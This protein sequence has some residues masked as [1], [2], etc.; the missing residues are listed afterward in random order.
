VQMPPKLYVTFPS[1]DFR[2]MPC[3][4]PK[5]GLGCIKVV[6]VH[7]DNPARHRL[8]SV[9]AT[10]I[11]IDP[12]TGSPLAIMDGTWIT[13]MRT[14]AAGGIAAKHLARRGSRVI[15]L[16]GAGAQARTQLLALN[17]V[18]DIDEVRVSA[19][20][21]GE[22]ERFR[23]SMKKLG[24]RIEIKESIED[25]VK[26]CD[27]LVTTTPVTRPIVMDDWISEGTHINAI[28]ADAPGKEELDPRILKRAKI[29]VDE[30]E[31]ACHSGEINVPLSKGLIRKEDIYG[32]LGEIIVDK[33]VGRTSEREITVFDSTGLAIEDLAAASVIY[34]RAKEVNLG[35]EIDL[36]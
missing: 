13:D 3:Y 6:S 25:A 34:E 8:P 31:Q 14:G 32:E 12:E 19:K 17:E 33:K 27:V 9:I 26:G 36:L 15:G 22:C 5:L 10:I 18:L 21:L 1:G 29:V 23:D 28:G 30:F 24:L 11:L 2:S 4:V 16:V 35:I 7:P 20:T